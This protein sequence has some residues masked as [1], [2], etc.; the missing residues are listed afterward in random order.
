MFYILVLNPRSDYTIKDNNGRTA[1]AAKLGGQVGCPSV[2]STGAI[3]G[4][5]FT[6]NSCKPLLCN[7]FLL[8]GSMTQ[9]N[10][11]CIEIPASINS[12]HS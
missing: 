4:H 2:D 9:F 5:V 7:L 12:T 1:S 10:V 8:K 11:C 6:N 3:K